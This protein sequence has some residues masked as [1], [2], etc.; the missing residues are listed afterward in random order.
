[1]FR[2]RAGGAHEI[3]RNIIRLQVFPLCF[4]VI[5]Y[6]FP[7]EIYGFGVRLKGYSVTVSNKVLAQHSSIFVDMHGFYVLLGVFSSDIVQKTLTLT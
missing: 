1:M 3:W 6:S 2:R 7:Y 4:S 5:V